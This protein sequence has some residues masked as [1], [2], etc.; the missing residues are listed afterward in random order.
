MENKNEIAHAHLIS[1]AGA[2]AVSRDP[3]RA[4]IKGTTLAGMRD[5]E[6]GRGEQERENFGRSNRRA[7]RRA[8]IPFALTRGD[9]E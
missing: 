1:C 3:A 7:G 2:Q 6:I 9:A 8:R 4:A 5:R